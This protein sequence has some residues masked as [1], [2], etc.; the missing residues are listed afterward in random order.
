MAPQHLS[1]AKASLS[2]GGLVGGLGLLAGDVSSWVPSLMG[3]ESFLPSLGPVEAITLA[4]LA[5]SGAGGDDGLKDGEGG[6]A[7]LRSGRS[8]RG[9]GGWRVLRVM[10]LQGP[11][12]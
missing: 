12:G 9:V 8:G 4:A 6:K 3:L 7:I 11:V 2:T 10:G 1:P 5:A